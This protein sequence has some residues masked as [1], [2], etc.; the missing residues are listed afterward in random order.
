MCI[1]TKSISYSTK[2][3]ANEDAFVDQY[4]KH[5]YAFV[6]DGA[7]PVNGDK[8]FN[9]EWFVNQIKTKLPLYLLKRDQSLYTCLEHTLS[10]IRNQATFPSSYNDVS[11]SIL[12]ARNINSTQME[13][14]TLGDCTAVVRKLDNSLEEI[15]TEALT[16]L[17]SETISLAKK[18]AD[19][20][21]IS[22]IEA[23]STDEVKD[24]IKH[25]RSLKNTEDGYQTCDPNG[26]GVKN[27]ESRYFDLNQ[28]HSFLLM[29]DGFAELVTTVKAFETYNDLI[30]SIQSNNLKDHIDILL[31]KQ[32]EDPTLDKYPRFKMTDDSTA[33]YVEINSN[34]DPKF[35]NPTKY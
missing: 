25:V 9:A 32:N 35:Y 14:F 29:T 7:T 19:E 4:K 16:I 23:L 2:D 24:R 26:M 27:A 6:I 13:I 18:R 15:H 21:N 22:M 34:T 17:D 28:I 31:E 1:A 10:D 20:N 12:I 30:L 33:I 11:C 5:G 3:R 8:Y